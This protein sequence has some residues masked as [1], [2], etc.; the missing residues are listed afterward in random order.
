LAYLRLKFSTVGFLQY[1]APT[2]SLFLGVVIF[3]E[4]FTTTHLLSFG[5]IWLALIIYT[6]SNMGILKNKAYENKLVKQTTRL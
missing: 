1:I 4:P 3:K 2:L 6:L 5:F